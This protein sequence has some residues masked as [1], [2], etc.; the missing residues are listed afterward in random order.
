MHGV[1]INTQGERVA[2]VPIKDVSDMIRSK[3]PKG[4]FSPGSLNQIVQQLVNQYKREVNNYKESPEG[5]Q[6]IA[7]MIDAWKIAARQIYI[8]NEVLRNRPSSGVFAN[9]GCRVTKIGHSFELKSMKLSREH[10]TRFGGATND[11]AEIILR[12]STPQGNRFREIMQRKF[13]SEVNAYINRIIDRLISNANIKFVPR[14][15]EIG[16]PDKNT[17]MMYTDKVI[18]EYKLAH[19]EEDYSKITK[20]RLRKIMKWGTKHVR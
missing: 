12:E 14:K 16:V 4:S 5:K 17:Y 11:Y 6:L 7:N 9:Y 3:I 1:S 18:F 13:E 19:P 2:F 8:A 20:S 10:A 15:T